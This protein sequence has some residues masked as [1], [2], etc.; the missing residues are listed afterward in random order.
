M[1][2]TNQLIHLPKGQL[3]SECF[4]E[5]LN[6][7]INHQKIRQISAQESK[8]WPNHKKNVFNTLNSPYNHM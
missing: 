2:L 7:P 6:F 1:V 3:I 5:F 4:F 8:M